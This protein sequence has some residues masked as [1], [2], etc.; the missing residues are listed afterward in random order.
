MKEEYGH[1]Y[2]EETVR[3]LKDN[4]VE[5]SE[6]EKIFVEKMKEYTNE[7]DWSNLTSKDIVRLS[8]IRHLLQM[9]FDIDTMNDLKQIR[10]KR[11]NSTPK[12]RR[13]NKVPGGSGSER[14]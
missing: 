8:T 9:F 4:K 6:D 3:F 7:I 13:A 10:E 12:S 14:Y 5:L 1:G 2:L 11:I